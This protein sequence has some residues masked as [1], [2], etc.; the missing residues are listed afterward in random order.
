MAHY[1]ND[2]TFGPPGSS[3]CQQ[4]IQVISETCRD[5]GVTLA[6]EIQEGPADLARH[7]D[8][9]CRGTIFTPSVQTT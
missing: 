7:S 5:H 2:M 1:L 4:N 6:E 3:E 8:R 9:H